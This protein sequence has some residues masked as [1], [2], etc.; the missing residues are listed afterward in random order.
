MEFPSEYDKQ[1]IKISYRT[2]KKLGHV[3]FVHNVFRIWKTK[4]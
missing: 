3:R 1:S 2:I 4:V